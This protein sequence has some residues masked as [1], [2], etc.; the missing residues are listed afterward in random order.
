MKRLII[1]PLVLALVLV[2]PLSAPV[3]AAAGSADP[4]AGVDLTPS[5][6][7]AATNVVPVVAG[8]AVKGGSLWPQ[9]DDGTS[10]SAADD[11]ATYCLALSSAAEKEVPSSTCGHRLPPFTAEPATTGT[12]FVAATSPLGVRSTPALGSAEPAAAA[13]GADSGETSTSART[14]GEMINRFMSVTSHKR[15]TTAHQRSGRRCAN[16]QAHRRPLGAQPTYVLLIHGPLLPASIDPQVL[17]TVQITPINTG[18]SA[19]SVDTFRRAGLVRK[20][21]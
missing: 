4:S 3:A 19:N 1:S 9:V 10:F 21:R 13:T 5:G 18:S 8:S 15:G 20:A 7:V 17:D 14:S 16:R 11:S 6:D 12:T 2:S